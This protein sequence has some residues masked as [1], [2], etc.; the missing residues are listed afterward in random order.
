[1]KNQIEQH[2]TELDNAK[3]LYKPEPE[4]TVTPSDERRRTIMV[5]MWQRMADYFGPMWESAYGTVEDPA[6]YSWQGALDRY[7]E[8]DLAGAI[9][10]CQDWDG[11]FPPTFPEFKSLVM[12][13]R[14]AQA[15]N[16]ATERVKTEVKNLEHFTKSQRGDS[17]IAK[18]EKARMRA[19]L[20]GEEVETKEESY[21][22]LHLARRWGPL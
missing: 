4:E 22:K 8:T 11:R 2:K 19:I 7:S 5:A 17:E 18:R 13:A 14:S 10:S 9:K 16:E 21:Q 6:I 20:R 1:M 12:A 15:G 3:R